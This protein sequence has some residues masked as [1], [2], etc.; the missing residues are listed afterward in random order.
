MRAML[1][2][3]QGRAIRFPEERWRHIISEHADMALLEDTIGATLLEPDEIFRDPED[4]ETVRLYYRWFYDLP[5]FGIER[6][7]V[8]VKVFNGDAFVVTAFIAGHIKG[9]ELL[10]RKLNG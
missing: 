1:L 8:T 3:Y 5:G 2:D 10:W 9:D 4:P 7:C 6:I